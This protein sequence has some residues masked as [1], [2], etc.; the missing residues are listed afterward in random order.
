[1]PGM[2]ELEHLLRQQG[3][4]ATSAQLLGVLSRRGLQSRLRTGEL[5]KLASVFFHGKTTVLR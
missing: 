1:M 3:G 5:I 2:V 4:V